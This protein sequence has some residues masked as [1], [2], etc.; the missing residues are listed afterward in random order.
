M[1]LTNAL[2]SF[3]HFINDVLFPFLDIFV[4]AYLNDFLIYFNSMEK[5]QGHR[6]NVIEALSKTR[7][8]LKVQKCKLHKQ[9]VKYLRWRVGNKRG[10][11]DLNMMAAVK[12]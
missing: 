4:T 11:I 2:P 1:R 6:R 5:H 8:H 12:D 3:Q 7:L 10:K 9:D